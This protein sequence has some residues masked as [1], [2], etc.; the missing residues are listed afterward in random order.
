M[1]TVN[2]ACKVVPRVPG[3][4]GREISPFTNATVP[5]TVPASF[6]I[7]N[8]FMVASGPPVCSRYISVLVETEII[9]A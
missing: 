8:P 6:L 4:G 2:K 7:I 1:Y 3:D 5:I 9:T